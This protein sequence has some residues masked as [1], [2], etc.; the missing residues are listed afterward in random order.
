MKVMLI[1]GTDQLQSFLE[2][3]NL[4]N[5]QT[6]K[7][8]LLYEKYSFFLIKILRNLSI[9]TTIWKISNDTKIEHVSEH[10]S[11]QNQ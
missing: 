9:C 7:H 3:S 5:P 1:Y 6:H 10:L 4:H 8:T 11:L 2:V